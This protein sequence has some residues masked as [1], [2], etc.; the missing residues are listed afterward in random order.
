MSNE[1]AGSTAFVFEEKKMTSLSNVKIGRK[2][3]LVLGGNVLVLTLLSALSLWGIRANEQLSAEGADL[4]A[5]ARLAEV[6]AGTD[7]NINATVGKMVY[8]KKVSEDF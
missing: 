5:Q 3:G 1:A 4:L 2:I 6:I 8:D 7:A